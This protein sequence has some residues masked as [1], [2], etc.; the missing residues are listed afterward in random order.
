MP[1]VSIRQAPGAGRPAR[2]APRADAEHQID[3]QFS[4]NLARGLD[5]LRAFTPDEPVLGNRELADRTGLPKPTI[6]R[7]TYTLTLLGYLAY[8]ER[9]QKY[10]LGAGVLSMGYPLLASLQV[11]QVARPV[12]E[13]IARETGCTVNLGMRDRT[14][15]VYVDT[16][17]VDHGNLYQP[18]IGSSRPLL[19][20]SIGRA[21]IVACA[22]DARAAIVNRI[23]VQEPGQYAAG[24]AFWEA[25]WRAFRE[26]GFCL[27]RGDWRK[28]VHAVAV[29]IRLPQREEPVALNCTTSA[30]RLARDA[31]QRKVAPILVEG[32]RAIEAACGVV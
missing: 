25:D 12:M 1:A 2:A 11:R 14:Q 30:H 29:P 27:S 18:D 19:L 23:K 4:N 20:T 26:R 22:A 31:L 15:V 28:E 13:R 10:R 16:C 3:R 32:V 8:V 21:I 7:L 9:L 6:S 24:A 5:V 17:R